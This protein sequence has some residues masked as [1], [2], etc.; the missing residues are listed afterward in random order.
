MDDYQLSG[1][2][3]PECGSLIQWADCTEQHCDDGYIRLHEL[4]PDWYDEDDLEVCNSCHG[5]GIREWCSN[6]GC[7][8]SSYLASLARLAFGGEANADG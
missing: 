2:F 5:T 7:N 8:Y 3:C 1:D 4:A 6:C